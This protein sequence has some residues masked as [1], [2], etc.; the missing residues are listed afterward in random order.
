ME[1]SGG[2]RVRA[3]NNEI[4]Q[5]LFD[6]DFI[7]SRECSVRKICGGGLHRRAVRQPCRRRPAKSAGV[8]ET[9]LIV[10]I[11]STHR[12]VHFDGQTSIRTAG[13]WVI[14]GAH[15]H[16]QFAG[17]TIFNQPSFEARPALD[18]KEEGLGSQACH[19]DS[20]AG[21]RQ[22]ATES[23]WLL[24]IIGNDAGWQPEPMRT[25]MGGTEKF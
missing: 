14:T 23:A 11:D 10:F 20:V 9:T 16:F 5:Y 4:G 22:P 8:L 2:A 25:H 17:I 15:G 24:I 13:E 1:E 18:S 12:S 6:S 21:S 19:A 7:V 3:A